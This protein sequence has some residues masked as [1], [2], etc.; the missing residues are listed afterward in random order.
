MRGLADRGK[1]VLFAT[2]YLEEAD[3]YADR[4]V[5]MAQRT[6]VADGPSTEVKALVGARTIRATLPGIDRR[7][8]P[9]A[10]GRERC[11]S[12]R[13]RRRAHLLRLRRGV[14][15]LFARHHGGPR[16]RGRRRRPR[17]GLH[18]ADRRSGRCEE[19]LTTLRPL[20]AAAHVPQRPLL[21]LLAGLPADPL[22]RRGRVEEEHHAERAPGA[23]STTWSGWSPGARWPRSCAAWRAHRRRAPGGLEPPAADHAADVRTYFATKVGTAYVIAL[24]SIALLFIAGLTRSASACRSC[25]WLG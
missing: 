8:A 22:L 18:A 11:R 4:V 25:S 24:V 3:E 6:V 5:L 15:A 2:H 9:L 14:R 7:R 12:P 20:R 19:R 13:R 21:H 17:A 16:R 1:T 10:A 23:D